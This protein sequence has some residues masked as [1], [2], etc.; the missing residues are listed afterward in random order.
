MAGS[1]GSVELTGGEGAFGGSATWRSLI[2]YP[3]NT[4]KLYISLVLAT[5]LVVGRF[6][7]PN[8]PTEQKENRM[9]LEI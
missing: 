9:M 2:S 7:V 6:S 3:L 5:G 1:C 4:M 8:D